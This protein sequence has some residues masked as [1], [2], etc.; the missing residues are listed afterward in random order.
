M[1]TYRIPASLYIEAE[2]VHAA[3][4]TA[5]TYLDEASYLLT[6]WETITAVDVET[7]QAE[8]CPPGPVDD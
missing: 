2:D 4:Q 3:M 5:T 6:N 1:P 7:D 8:E